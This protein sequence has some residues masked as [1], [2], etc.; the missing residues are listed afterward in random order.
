MVGVDLRLET[1]DFRVLG[2]VSVDAPRGAIELGGT[3]QRVL[4]A[5]LLL[6]PNESVSRDR[7]IDLLWSDKPP[8]K[9]NNS[10]HVQVSKLRKALGSNRIGTDRAGYFLR[11]E[12]DELDL[13]VFRRLVARAREARRAGDATGAAETLRD[14]LS[15]WRDAPFADLRYERGLATEIAR[16]EEGEV[17]SPRGTH[18]PLSRA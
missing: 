5:L 4:L 17:G 18:R 2:A 14:A 7:V 3:K 10:L 12:E 9:A 6:H 13:N 8:E 15:L 11:I 1:L 16:L